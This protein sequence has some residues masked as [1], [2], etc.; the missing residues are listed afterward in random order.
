MSWTTRML[1]YFDEVEDEHLIVRK[2]HPVLDGVSLM[3]ILVAPS[4]LRRAVVI[5]D[6]GESL[7]FQSVLQGLNI[8]MRP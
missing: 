4:F 2:G 8:F 5:E 6:L 1:E 3:D 7:R